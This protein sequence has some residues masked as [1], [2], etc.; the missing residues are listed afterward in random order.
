MGRLI[1]KVFPFLGVRFISV[2]D[3]LDTLN[4]TD[5]KKSF[6]V[7]LKNII[8]DLYAKDISVKIKSAKENRAKNGYFIGSVPPYGYKVVKPKEGQKLELDED[9]CTIAREMFDLT[10]SGL[11]Q[12]EVAKIFNT[13][14]YTTPMVYYK[15][16]RLKKLPVDPE[17]SKGSI[18]KILTKLAYT[19]KLVQGVKQQNLAKGIKWHFAREDEY[20][21]FENAHEP[22]I[23]EE[24][25]QKILEGR[26]ERK[27]LSYFSRKQ[28]D[29]DRDPENRFKGKVF[30][31]YSGKE[32]YRRLVIYGKNKDRFH[33]IFRNERSTG[34]LKEE[35]NIHITE[36]VIDKNLTE[37]V[38]SLI[39]SNT[40]K[41]RLM[42]RVKIRYDKSLKS[43]DDKLKKLEKKIDREET[44]LK[45]SYEKYKENKLSLKKYRLRR[46][47]TS[48]HINN[49]KLERVEFEDKYKLLEVELEKSIKWI[50]N[51]YL[52]TRE[53]RL[54][55]DLIEA[56]VEKI[57]IKNKKEFKIVFTFSLEKMLGGNINE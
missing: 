33:Y 39:A 43:I 42:E 13:K 40:S 38:R 41:E 23:T 14:G 26:K 29:F 27:D 11:S 53:E 48:N 49:F 16:G 21:I 44:E 7:T 35:P 15:T 3:K 54:S 45:N 31:F 12:F 19:G 47:I 9:T 18:S 20:I 4:N 52:A 34:K 22:I 2:N 56:L 25:H 50:E 1:D 5:S 8:N 36:K 24:E 28:H 30:S 55:R 37:I 57:I 51:L 6:E 46:E 10:L 32:L 17:W